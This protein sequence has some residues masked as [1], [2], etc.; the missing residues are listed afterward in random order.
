MSFQPQAYRSGMVKVTFAR[1]WL[2]FLALSLMTTACGGGGGGGTPPAPPVQTMTIQVQVPSN[3]PAGDT[4]WMRTGMLFGVDEQEVAMTKVSS[5]PDVWQA[6]VT[7]PEGTIL[8]YR[9]SRATA[10]IISWDKEE[11]NVLRSHVDGFHFREAL[12][13]KGGTV[14]ETIAKWEDLA[15]VSGS[16][17]TLAGTVRDQGGSP[18]MGIRVSAGPHQTMTRRDG[19]YRV[20]GV[21]AGPCEI[22]FRSDNGEYVQGRASATIS[23]SG[24]TTVN[25]NM[26]AATMVNVTFNVTLPPMTMPL[27]AKP[28]IFGD[29]YRLG[30]F[31]VF[32]GTAMETARMIDMTSAGG[33]VWTYTSNLGTGSCFNY[34][35]TLGYNHV[36]NER[37]GSGNPVVRSLCVTGAMTVNDTV[38]S[39]RAPWHVPVTLTATS[40]TGTSDALYVTT[41]DWGGYAPMRMWSTDGTTASYVIFTDPSTTINYRY[42]RN[43]DPAIG[44]GLK[45]AGT[46]S[47]NPYSWSVNSGASGTV[48]NDTVA[49]WRHQ[50]RETPLSTVTT[51]MTGT[52]ISRPTTS[53]F[54][55]GVELI[56]YWRAAWKP[57]IVPTLDRIKSKNAQWVQIASV[58]GILNMDNPIAEIGWNSF[59]PEELV[60]HIQAAKSANLKVALRGFTY[61]ADAV[62]EAKFNDPHTNAWFDQFFD[63]VKTALLYHAAIAQQEGVDMLILPNF[64]WAEDGGPNDNATTRTYI[65]GKWTAIIAAVRAVYSGP[66]TTDYLV[67]R[68]SEYTWYGLLDYLGDKWWV[69]LATTD[70]DTVATMYTA[71][72]DKLVNYYQ[73]ISANYGNKPFVF[74]EVAYYSANTSA[75]HQYGVYDPEL[76]DFVPAVAVPA[77]D[78]DEQARAYQATLLAFAETPWVQGCYSFGYAYFDFD[79]KGYSVRAKTAENIMSQI[80]QQINDAVTP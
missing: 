60:E 63:E 2:A 56:D 8:R 72:K 37:D 62:E 49:V 52:V 43:G 65:N 3:T 17:G 40:P 29:T 75:M 79:S 5:S 47:S 33:G 80:Y 58:W 71:A 39:W 69:P 26:T 15:L 64:N 11:T 9:Y 53:A 73:P 54:Q 57:L 27:G 67:Y 20:Y 35:Y 14:S 46:D 48:V 34:T 16:T 38:A 30:M 42:V 61:P 21:P 10:M 44:I 6:T 1:R 45:T 68:P 50:M 36:N 19:T 7:A 59:T 22:T 4:I 70:T 28:R 13:R 78:Y 74:A 41:D 18:L 76:G 55:T 77:S 25:T 66:L 23:S 51:S 32:E 24:T 12:V 31:P